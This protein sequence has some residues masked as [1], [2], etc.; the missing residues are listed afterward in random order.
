MGECLESR[1]YLKPAVA[2]VR[3]CWDSSF[4]CLPALS[5][6]NPTPLHFI[7]IHSLSLCCEDQRALEI[8]HKPGHHVCCCLNKKPSAQRGSNKSSSTK[9]AHGR[10][11][12]NWSYFLFFFR[13]LNVSAWNIDDLKEHLKTH[14]WLRD[15]MSSRLVVLAFFYV[16]VPP[17]NTLDWRRSCRWTQ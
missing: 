5:N 6:P 11:I 9:S 14:A 15:F 2:E 12:K 7:S 1:V 17:S 13:W 16:F 4:A 8:I 3:K 10:Q